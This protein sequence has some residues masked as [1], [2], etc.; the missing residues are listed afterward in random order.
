MVARLEAGD[1]TLTTTRRRDVPERHRS[2]HNAFESSFRRLS[3]DLQR[4]FCQLSLFRGGWSLPA[5][6]AVSERHDA[7]I[8]LTELA[9]ASLII[10]QECENGGLRYS[11]LE[12]LRQFADERLTDSERRSSRLR[13]L[14]LYEG[15]AAQYPAVEKVPEMEIWDEPAW[16][17]LLSIEWDNILVAL[18]TALSE[19][20][21]DAAVFLLQSLERFW[22]LNG[23]REEAC[24]WLEQCLSHP[25]LGERARISAQMR[26][27][28]RGWEW[29]GLDFAEDLMR[30]ALAA[31]EA[32]GYERETADAYLK[33]GY[34]NR[35][36][37]RFEEAR[38]CLERAA[39][40]FA[41]MNH[42]LQ[43]SAALQAIGTLYTNQGISE[44]AR[45]YQNLAD[46]VLIGTPFLSQRMSVLYDRAR[47]AFI[48]DQFDVA[49]TML[50]ECIGIARRLE[51]GI[52]LG[53]AANLYGEAQRNLGNDEEGLTYL[54]YS[55]QVCARIRNRFG[56]HYPTWN[57][58]LML[59]ESQ[60]YELAVPLL[61]YSLALWES[62]S[63]LPLTRSEAQ[64]V[65]DMRQ[66]AE[67]DL[68]PDKT[69]FLWQRGKGMTMVDAAALAERAPLY[70]KK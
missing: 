30:E 69:A 10:S 63:S 22:A 45:R 14:A 5:A 4:F 56:M 68:G 44:E 7:A 41:R 37:D 1:T 20:M 8:L 52:M 19:G 24:L 33:M 70:K 47:V 35:Y 6:E 67:E 9:D 42:R 15:L 65:A 28:H 12:S 13:H 61:A 25:E 51:D 31:A 53:Q 60:N 39:E 62:L 36:R 48:K 66:G 46:D 18:R 23:R 16:T 29:K 34:I 43:Q 3:P 57:L 64:E 50:L 38:Q 17:Q 26:L 55:I 11:C 40:R 27:A 49:A 32:H 54:I 2:L 59:S 58:A 21:P